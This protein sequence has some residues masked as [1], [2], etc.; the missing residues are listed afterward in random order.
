MSALSFILPD[1]NAIYFN[2][3][4]RDVLES[5]LPKLRMSR[6]T[7]VSKVAPVDGIKFRFDLDGYLI[8]QQVPSY[9]HW[10]IARINGLKSSQE[11]GPQV[12]FLLIPDA[13]ELEQVRQIY[14]TTR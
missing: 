10:V 5:Y 8:A 3:S 13:D 12:E 14:M 2:Q 4:F 11:F 9:L 1:S 7:I 6:G